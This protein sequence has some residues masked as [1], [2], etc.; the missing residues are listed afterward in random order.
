MSNPETELYRDLINYLKSECVVR[1]LKC[2]IQ[3]I[4]SNLTSQGIPD[5]NLCIEGHE[6]WIECKID[7][8]LSPMQISWRKQRLEAGG[9]VFYLN[10]RKDDY[11]LYTP[12]YWWDVGLQPI[13]DKII[14][15]AL[16]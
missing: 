15:E 9:K 2:H 7:D 12:Y 13:V 6:V 5:I 8:D 14:T 1:G 10:K 3:R 11:A 4:E 16:K